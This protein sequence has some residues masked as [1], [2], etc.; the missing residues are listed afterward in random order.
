MPPFVVVLLELGC[1][2]IRLRRRRQ[3]SKGG[4]EREKEK[5]TKDKEE[6]RRYYYFR[7]I[8]VGKLLVGLNDYLQSRRV[9]ISFDLV[10]LR[11][12]FCSLFVFCIPEKEREKKKKKLV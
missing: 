7:L 5:R 10:Q 8:I 3:R 9:E 12:H 1:A 4:I 6:D 2:H 11:P